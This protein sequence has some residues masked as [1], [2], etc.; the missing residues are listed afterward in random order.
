MPS[1]LRQWIVE[2]LGESEKCL[3]PGERE[4]SGPSR[5]INPGKDENSNFGNSTEQSDNALPYI[6]ASTPG[7]H[8]YIEVQQRQAY[9]LYNGLWLGA[10]YIY[11][12]SYKLGF[13]APRA[14]F[15]A[16]LMAVDMTKTV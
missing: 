8:C 12:F 3:H 1:Y 7:I 6:S 11:I 13:F 14:T 15:K 16:V 10:T 4:A 2:K 5:E 9:I